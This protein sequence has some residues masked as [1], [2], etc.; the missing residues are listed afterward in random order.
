MLRRAPP[1]AL[2][3]VVV[4]IRQLLL[5][6]LIVQDALRVRTLLPDLIL[7]GFMRGPVVAELI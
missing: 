3:R 4:Q 7:V 2:H 5:H 1:A 6:H